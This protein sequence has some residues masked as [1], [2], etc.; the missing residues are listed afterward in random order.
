MSVWKTSSHRQG[1]QG[2]LLPPAWNILSSSGV[3]R[4]RE[5]VLPA[6]PS[7]RHSRPSSASHFTSQGA[8]SRGSW[9]EDQPCDFPGPL[10]WM[11]GMR[12]ELL[13]WVGKART[14]PSTEE[15]TK[16]R[17]FFQGN[18]PAQG[19]PPISMKVRGGGQHLSLVSTVTPKICLAK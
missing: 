9:R 15:Q 16:S 13:G 10:S 6:E 2:L 3:I 4:P 18:R 14:L 11:T 17:C 19:K 7:P 12:N 5:C 1:H 8:P